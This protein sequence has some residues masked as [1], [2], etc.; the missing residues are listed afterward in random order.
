MTGFCKVFLLGN[1]TRDPDMRTSHKGTAV[2][3]LGIAVNSDNRN[4][5]PFFGQVVVFGK[6]AEACGRYLAKGSQILVEGRLKNEEWED[7]QTGQKRS[8]TRIYADSVQFIGRNDNAR[9][10][11]GSGQYSGYSAQAPAPQSYQGGAAGV[12]PQYAPPLPGAD[13]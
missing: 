2:C 6:T 1:L 13:Y 5:P 3:E 8:K 11:A 9:Q 7:R 10:N 12:E 4:D